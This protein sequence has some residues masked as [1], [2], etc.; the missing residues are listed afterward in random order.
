MMNAKRAVQALALGLALTMAVSVDAD[1]RKR[2]FLDFELGVPKE[3]VVLPPVKG[4]SGDAPDRVYLHNKPEMFQYRDRL[5]KTTLVWFV[6]FTLKNP[7][8][9]QYVPLTVDL[10]L[11]TESG[12]DFN[13]DILRTDPATAARGRFYASVVQEP[14]L[15]LRIISRLEKLGNRNEE[16]QRE[17][18]QEL[19]RE[20]KYLNP[21][22]LRRKQVLKPG[23]E[24]TGL[25]IYQNV[26]RTSD[27]LELAI[28]GL[29]DVARIVKIDRERTH[30]TY[31]NKVL[32]YYFDVPG[33][34]FGKSSDFV[35]CGFPKS[36]KWDVMQVL[37]S[38]SKE[39]LPV[40]IEALAA[41]DPVMDEALKKRLPSVVYGPNVRRGAYDSLRKLTGLDYPFDADKPPTEPENLNTIRLFREWWTRN[42]EKLVYN[43]IMNRFE[44][45][46]Q[47]IPGSVDVKPPY[48]K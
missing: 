39:D 40:L 25:A 16:M 6:P 41:D 29:V 33:D 8:K 46:P 30:Y 15:E 24:V 43:D 38:C 34:E 5:G 3:I 48:A 1:V 18:V 37:P 21:A 4:T 26:D 31:E 44:V 28:D 7:S 12:R 36:R 20:N 13:H 2:W 9:D 27:T 47:V 19:K 32:H 10:T 35:S 14:D 22:E 17:R 45:K 42:S 11:R 23:E